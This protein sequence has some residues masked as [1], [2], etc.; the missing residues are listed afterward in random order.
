MASALPNPKPQRIQ[1]RTLPPPY[2]VE[3]RS[4]TR[5]GVRITRRACQL[6]DDDNLY[7]G[8]KPLIDC[9]REFGLIPEDDTKTIKLEC[10]QVRVQN[11]KQEGTE[12][13]VLNYDA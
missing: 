5:I 2:E 8:A 12:I 13:E 11:R 9:L 10:R 6:L 7:G 1:S 4:E 3:T